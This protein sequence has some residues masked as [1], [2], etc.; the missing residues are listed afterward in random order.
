MTGAYRE[1]GEVPEY[2]DEYWTLHFGGPIEW[3]HHIVRRG[4]RESALH[5]SESAR[6][7]LSLAVPRDDDWM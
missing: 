1:P 6:A 2:P 4:V 3:V 7:G 5:L